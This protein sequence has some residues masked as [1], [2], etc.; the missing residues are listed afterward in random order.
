MCAVAVGV[1]VSGCGSEARE[2]QA[3]A[4]VSVGTSAESSLPATYEPA[5]PP[6]DPTQ[7]PSTD[8]ITEPPKLLVTGRT[9]SLDIGTHCGVGVLSRNVHGLAWM[10]DEANGATGWMPS[11]WLPQRR[12]YEVLTVLV[13]LSADESQLTATYN[14]RA[15]VYRKVTPDDPVFLC[16]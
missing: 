8:P 15:I 5:A 1:T 3:R 9:Y 14:E 4:N 7:V 2:S 12:G 13:V 11:E 6:V 10:T 16:A